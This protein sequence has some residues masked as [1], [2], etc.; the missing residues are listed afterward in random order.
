MA[1]ITSQLIVSLIDKVSGPAKSVAASLKGVVAAEKAAAASVSK[2][3]VGATKSVDNLAKT[4]GKAAATNISFSKGF[5]DQLGTLNL[6]QKQMDRLRGSFDKYQSSLRAT[7]TKFHDALPKLDTWERDTIG[8]L[9]RAGKAHEDH[10]RRVSRL[11][12]MRQ[13]VK[14][15]AHAI[16]P[17]AGAYAVGHGT[18]LAVEKSAEMQREKM[19]EDLA[20]MSPSDRASTLAKA[21]DLTSKYGSVGQVEIMEQQ[22]NLRGT[23]G[24][25]HHA[26]DMIEDVVKSQVV[27]A[28]GA[29]GKEGATRDLD[30]ITKGLEGAGYAGSPDKFRRML[31]AFV[32]AKNMFGET[33]TGEDF[34]TYLQRAK[35]TKGGLSE[36][37]LAGVVPT[38]IQHEGANQFGT[39]QATAFNSLIGGRQTKAS[40]AKLK[41]FGILGDD[42]EVIDKKLLM[43]DPDLWANKNLAPR[44]QKAGMSMDTDAGSD[45]RGKAVE[46]LMKAFSNRNAGEF[47]ASLLANRGV[48]EKD[49]ANLKGARGPEAADDVIKNDPFQGWEKLKA[50]T[51]N[52][53]QDILENGTIIQNGLNLIAS[54]VGALAK[55][56]GDASPTAK[57]AAS[58]VAEAAGV[59]V[60]G[61]AAYLIGKKGFNW[62]RGA[63]PAG[64]A[65]DGA[66][67]AAPVAEPAAGAAVTAAGASSSAWM[68]T[69]AEFMPPVVATVAAIAA[70]FILRAATADDAGT[71]AGDRLNKYRGGSLI[72]ARRRA[73]NDENE[74]FGLPT[75]TGTE[76]G[77]GHATVGQAGGDGS[78]VWN[79]GTSAI[80]GLQGLAG[81]AG[82]AGQ[83]SGSA[84]STNLGQGLDAAIAKAISAAEQ[85]KAALN[86]NV[87]P[88]VTPKFGPA[89]TVGKGASLD[90]AAAKHAAFADTGFDTV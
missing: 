55:A 5:A 10:R 79:K 72:E 62:I 66:I 77:T 61:L 76:G 45:E 26:Q 42:G 22:R 40:K 88:T 14:E 78:D 48:I 75:V 2:S 86:F 33:L 54:G 20:G 28:T 71:T 50:Q 67:A 23:L 27:L 83:A 21:R 38:M 41:A 3:A 51:S 1:S 87:S 74:R 81:P 60:G 44:M 56:L 46:F 31:T 65:L 37:Y 84:F 73:Y 19:R 58:T 82:Q 32:K 9:R 70:P 89:P 49:R 12:D 59:G 47:F 8:S 30:Q 6:T 29:G 17:I 80:S 69:V 11:G 16:V 43:S 36:D 85:I 53:A 63:G 13:G 34:R 7:G 15:A 18:K 52:L 57:T 64:G 24:D 68:A 90:G 39:A 4:V 35:T 25:L